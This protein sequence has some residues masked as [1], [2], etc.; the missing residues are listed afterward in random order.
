MKNAV[1]APNFREFG[2]LDKLVNLAVLAEKSGFDGFFLW[3]HINITG[4]EAMNTVDPTIALAAIASAT[5]SILVGP[6]VTPLAR[7]RPWKVSRELVSLDH[8]SKGE[9]FLELV[10]VS[11]QSL[12]LLPLEKI[13]QQR[14]ELEKLTKVLQ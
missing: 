5:N 8:L 13:P 14:F 3:D 6:V 2:C 1:Y 11:H 12:S 9:L 10:W 4:S 7:R